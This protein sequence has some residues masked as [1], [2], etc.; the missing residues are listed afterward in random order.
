MFISTPTNAHTSSIKVILKL[1]KLNLVL[2]ILILY[3]F[4]VHL[5]VL[6]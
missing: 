4:Y 3:Y 6:K 1:L 2:K 5:L